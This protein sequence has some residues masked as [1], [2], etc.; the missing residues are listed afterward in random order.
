MQSTI[1]ISRG[2]LCTKSQLQN[3]KSKAVGNTS[4]HR[5]TITTIPSWAHARLSR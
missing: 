3:L 4:T 1:N 5:K 2:S